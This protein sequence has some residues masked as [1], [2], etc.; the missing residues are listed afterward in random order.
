V[1][2]CAG[3]LI[4]VGAALAGN[5]GVLPVGPQSPNA[6]RIREAYIYILVFVAIIFVGVEGTLILFI[7]RYRRGKRPR[8]LEGIQIHGATRLE[9]LWTVVPAIILAAIAG[10]VFYQLPAITN[11]PSAS[12]ANE[13]TI[14]VEGHQFYWM[15]RYPNGAISVGTMVAPADEVVLENVFAVP[16]EVLHSWWAPALG[17]KIDAVPG[18][19]NH[20][21]FKAPV[22]TYA[23]RC[24]DL[25]G[26]QHTKMLAAVD[27]VPKATYE[28][29]IAERARRPSSIALGAEEFRY[30]C[31]VC[32]R[33]ATN[34]VG[35]A[36]GSNPLLLEPSH[37]E[38]IVR[39]GIGAMP[40]VGSDWT[41]DQMTALVRYTTLIT[42]AYRRSTGGGPS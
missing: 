22:G 32:H 23:A 14:G 19:T 4:V 41:Q 15:F 9:I 17:G 35:P 26:I 39:Q 3:A 29:F 7:A 1:V 34:Y 20:T 11:P 37:L 28:R 24:S 40:A 6:H 36:L 25:C 8:E 33:L 18:R 30:A 13:T 38:T 16:T 5:G 2:S 10:F 21:W 42:A 31:A 27:V 12:A